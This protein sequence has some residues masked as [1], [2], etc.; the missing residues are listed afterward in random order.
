MPTSS[1]QGLSG[2]RQA[3]EYLERTGYEILAHR[4]RYGRKEIDLV[5]RKNDLVIFVEVKKRRD[6]SFAPIRTSVGPAKQRNI[7]EAANGWLA[8]HGR[9]DDNIRYR[10]DVVLVLESDNNRRMSVEHIEDAFRA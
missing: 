10:F 3:A 9:D 8:Q 7:V 6:E 4:W 2:E 1:D 5:A